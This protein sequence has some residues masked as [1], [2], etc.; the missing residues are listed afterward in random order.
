MQGLL[1]DLQRFII[2]FNFLPI[3]PDIV[4]GAL[5]LISRDKWSEDLRGR[6]SFDLLISFPPIN[7]FEAFGFV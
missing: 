1:E 5:T 2:L 7:T 4:F 3:A 6:N